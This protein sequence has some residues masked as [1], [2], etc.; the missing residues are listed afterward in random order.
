MDY[1]EDAL[2]TVFAHH[3]PARGDPGT[4]S[5]FAD[6]ALAPSRHGERRIVY[7]IP[8]LSSENTRL[9]AHHQWDAGVHLAKMITT[10]EM[11]VRAKRVVELL[12]LIH[13]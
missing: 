11:D 6:E 2:F 13:I 10:R 5:V 8:E 1:F 12:S 3:Q 9:F 4:R 7:R